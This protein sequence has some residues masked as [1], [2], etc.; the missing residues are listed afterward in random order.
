MSQQASTPLK[1]S[2]SQLI[3]P[4]MNQTF[5]QNIAASVVSVQTVLAC[6]DLNLSLAFLTQQLG[7]KVRMIMPSD[8]PS[9]AVLSAYGCNLRLEQ[10]E[11]KDVMPQHLRLLC[12]LTKLPTGTPSILLGPDALVIELIDAHPPLEVPEAQQEFVL[13]R[14]NDDASWGL[15]RAG[16]LYRDL[17]PSRLGG[18]FVASHL[19]IPNAGPVADYVHFHRVRF[20][21]IYCKTGWVR[22]VYEDQGPPFILKA[23]DC[24]LQPPEIR[25]RVLE[26]SAGLEVIEIGCPAIHETCGDP[27]LNLPTEFCRPE[28]LFHEQRF[29]HHS[30]QSATWRVASQ[31]GFE[32]RDTGI[33]D[34]TSGLASVTVLRS[35]GSTPLGAKLISPVELFE[36]EFLFFFV[37]DGQLL[38]RSPELG[39]HSLQAGD[40]CVLPSGIAYALEASDHV[41][42]LQVA[43]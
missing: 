12:D 40:S 17:I 43:L 35:V 24:V 33:A 21:M 30:A 8:A 4:R 10:L 5:T 9:V 23:G 29:I 14:F 37:L 19:R 6:S 41:E 42:V 28:R 16:M 18:R 7:F 2:L 13:T 15:G 36:G 1:Q 25:H 11:P 31:Q 26:A 32:M 3:S 38:I 34:A 20:Q 39:M 22:L 27:E